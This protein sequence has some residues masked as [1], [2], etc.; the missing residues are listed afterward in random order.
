M[1]QYPRRASS[2]TRQNHGVK[3][4]RNRKTM[5]ELSADDECARKLRRISSIEEIGF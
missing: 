1:R 2:V 4:S 3:Q 5:R